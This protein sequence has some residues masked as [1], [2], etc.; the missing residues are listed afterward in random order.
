MTQK[1]ASRRVAGVRG[2]EPRARSLPSF[3]SARSDLCSRCF[4]F[5]SLLFA[6]FP[7]R[8]TVRRRHVGRMEQSRIGVQRQDCR[9]S[10][11]ATRQHQGVEEEPVRVGSVCCGTTSLRTSLDPHRASAHLSLGTPTLCCVY[12]FSRHLSAPSPSPC[13]CLC[14][15]FQSKALIQTTRRPP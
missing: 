3:G 9:D 14:L 12:P 10:H 8:V 6:F 15:F 4:V 5:R 2:A 1:R 13:F 7:S 11:G